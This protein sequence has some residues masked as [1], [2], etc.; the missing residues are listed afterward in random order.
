MAKPGVSSPV[1]QS[2]FQ[3]LYL[4]HSAVE[5]QCTA[6]VM[7]WII[8]ELKLRTEQRTLAWLTPGE[9]GRGS[10]VERDGQRGRGVNIEVGR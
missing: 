7:Q 3:V 2:L 8:E 10:S 4:G 5:R 6:A 9:E 1:S